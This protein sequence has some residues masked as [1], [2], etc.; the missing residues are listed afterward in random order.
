MGCEGKSEVCFDAVPPE[1]PEDV[2]IR[3]GNDGGD[4]SLMCI[5]VGLLHPK[6]V[7]LVDSMRME[8]S[9]S[10]GYEGNYGVQ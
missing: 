7:V 10:F 2:K 5:W 3:E 8:G 9:I 1:Q 6:V 4:R